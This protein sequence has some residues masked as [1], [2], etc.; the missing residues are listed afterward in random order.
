MA[1]TLVFPHVSSLGINQESRGWRD[2][3]PVPRLDETTFIHRIFGGYLRSQVRCTKC[4]YRSNTYD[5]FL[6]LALEVS[7]KSCDSIAS[8]FADF[9]RKETLD[10]DN[11]WKCSGC[12]KHVRATK[13]LTV[14]RGPLAL[15]VQLKRFTYGGGLGGYS[16][17]GGGWGY[18]L[19][20]A[21]TMFG[22]GTKITKPIDFPAELHLPLSDGRKCAYGLSGI[23][24]HVGGSSSSGHY[25]AFVKRPALSSESRSDWYHMDDSF[26]EP[27]S[28][29]AVLR[30]RDAY[31]L[32]YCRKEVKLEF[33][34]PPPR[35]S[36]TADEAKELGIARARARADSIGSINDEQFPKTRKSSELEVKPKAVVK[37]PGD[38]SVEHGRPP[39]TGAGLRP[40]SKGAG[41]AEI[42]KTDDGSGLSSE[43]NEED[44]SNAERGG[45]VSSAALEEEEGSTVNQGDSIPKTGRIAPA[46]SEEPSL[47]FKSKLEK[48][49]ARVVVDRGDMTRKLEVMVGPRH[50]T[51]KAWTPK[52]PSRGNHLLGSLTIETWGDGEEG[53]WQQTNAEI[54]NIAMNETKKE[55]RIRKRKMHLDRWDATLD[56]GKVRY[57]FCRSAD[58]IVKGPRLTF[59]RLRSMQA[60]KVKDKSMSPE[61]VTPKNNKFL[62]IQSSVQRMNRGHAKGR[63]HQTPTKRKSRSRARRASF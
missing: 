6:D 55:E 32:F 18:G 62:R 21:S 35:A 14:F 47:P 63:H 15:C 8:A 36:M 33:P 27:I 31:L 51:K 49:K 59:M 17:L 25:T 23:V 57:I 28:E 38:V 40:P 43:A 42:T 52:S 30:H 29:K 10:S 53:S 54:R 4:G 12:Q 34:T 2:R 37:Q 24:I 20:G 5:P 9:T 16:S 3:L 39:S 48:G 50:K 58:L 11:R 61:K 26:V 7:K 19:K 60:K 22:G 13:T 56:E 44:N 46:K 41:A 45:D 1:E